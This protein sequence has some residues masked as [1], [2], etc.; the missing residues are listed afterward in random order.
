M[1]PHRDR[2]GKCRV[3]T[4]ATVGKDED[5]VVPVS[6]QVVVDVLT[7]QAALALSQRTRV[8]GSSSSI[9]TFATNRFPLNPNSPAA[10]TFGSIAASRVHR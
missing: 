2:A 7:P 8:V 1:T 4:E 9:V 5:G 6:L 10:P 3:A